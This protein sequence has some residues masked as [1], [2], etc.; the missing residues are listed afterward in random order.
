MFSSSSISAWMT[1]GVPFSG[2]TEPRVDSDEEFNVKEHTGEF[3]VFVCIR[4][5]RCLD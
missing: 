3:E 1:T 5:E 2:K 4:F